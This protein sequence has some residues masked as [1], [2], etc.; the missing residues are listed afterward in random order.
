MTRRSQGKEISLLSTPPLL[1]GESGAEFASLHAALELEIDPNGII[2][3]LYV[4]DVTV[5]VW[6]IRRLRPCKSAIINNAIRSALQAL[7]R[8]LMWSPE[9]PYYEK[10]DAL[11]IEWYDSQEAKDKVSAILGRFHLDESAIVAQAIRGVLP[12]I[13]TIERMIASLEARRDKVLRCVADYR[14]SLAQRLRQTSDRIL[15]SDDLLGL[16]HSAS[17]KSKAG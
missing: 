16:E 13:E 5:I 2:E 12:E 3:K 7:L 14:D 17:K 1:F 9:Q 10:A 6:E 4:D 11:A 15:Q 8:E